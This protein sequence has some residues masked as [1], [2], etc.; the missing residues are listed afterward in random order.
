MILNRLKTDDKLPD[1]TTLKNVVILI[2]CVIKCGNKF[3]LQLFSKEAL[4]A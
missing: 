1:N 2:M 3:Y 4:A